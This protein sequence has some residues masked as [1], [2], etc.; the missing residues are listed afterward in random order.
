VLQIFDQNRTYQLRCFAPG[1]HFAIRTFM[2]V[3]AHA[4]DNRENRRMAAFTIEHDN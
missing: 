4:V 1:N 2:L 3:S